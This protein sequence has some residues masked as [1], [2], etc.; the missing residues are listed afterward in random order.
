[1][2]AQPQQDVRPRVLV[3]D[4]DDTTRMLARRS[5]ELAGFQVCE[6]ADGIEA[7]EALDRD[8]PDI[9]L[10]DVDMP[11]LDGFEAC[12]RIRAMPDHEMLPIL[13]ATSFE[14]AE[15]VDRAYA[16]GA[17]DFT[18]KPI[19]WSL[20]HHRVRYLLRASETLRNLTET[21]QALAQSRASLENAQRIARLGSWEWD[22]E[23]DRMR[24]SDEVYRIVGLEPGEVAPSLGAWLV[25]VHPQD[26]DAVQ[27]WFKEAGKG[28]D[29]ASIMHRVLLPDGVERHVQHR[30]STTNLAGS[31]D[32]GVQGTLQDVTERIHSEERLHRLAFYDGL[33][34]L[35]NRESFTERLAI[36]VARAKRRGWRLG[37]LVLDLDDFKRINDTLGHSVGDLLLRAVAERLRDCVRATDTV[38]QIEPASEGHQVARLGGDEFTLLLVDLRRGEDA[39]IV[40]NRVIE[41]LTEPF[42]LAGNET[43]IT[44]SVGIALFPNDGDDAE[45]LVKNADTA[46]YFAKRAGKNQSR[47]YDP[48]MND[49]ALRR[50]T[51]DAHLRRALE[52]G[53]L[54]LHYQPQL[55]LGSG[56]IDAAEALLRWRNPELGNVPPLDFIPLA[57]EN[58]MIIPIGDWVIRTAC[59]QAKEWRD[60]GLGVRRVAVNV[61]V[62]QFAQ[63]NF[64]DLIKTA[65]EDAGLEPDGLELEVTE[66]LLA[67]DVE[68]SV[69]TLNALREIGVQL[70]IDDFG[71]GYSSMSQLKHFPVDR[72]K[73]DRSF[74]KG[75]TSD[76]DDGAITMAVLSMA[77]SMNL[78]VV[79]E[80]VETQAQYEFFRER[81]CEQIQ[82]YYLSRPI[83]A[84]ELSSF[85]RR[86]A[87]PQEVDQTAEDPA[88]TGR[89][90]LDL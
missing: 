53:E 66:S 36:E 22:P 15:S 12:A 79:A 38:T 1:M 71:T 73:I 83:P 85:V 75:V 24:W 31:F 62:A 55:D 61:S 63:S 26:R 58:G 52:R 78:A 3:V 68:G 56:Q 17:T 10:L 39:G 7:L 81:R 18:N 74:V 23:G 88:S 13:M 9:V 51:L 32:A 54:E 60:H 21:A 27:C 11:R 42:S 33:T 77:K 19:N 45:T 80:G 65:L 49:L 67:K 43:F 47:F 25:R 2:S 41:R 90:R 8:Q 64:A 44:P 76:P 37:T 57:E 87:N 84:A 40:A 59:A 4:D 82:G 48:S 69:R 89:A 72:L 86:Y 14:D 30:T 50:L 70:S 29:A 6:A 34:D 5:L 20:L 16:A 46:M 35:P 28:V